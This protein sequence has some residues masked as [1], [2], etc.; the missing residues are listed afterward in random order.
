MVD[1]YALA[2]RL[3]GMLLMRN[4]QITI[5]EIQNLPFVRDKDEAYAVA[6]RLVQVFGHHH[7]IEFTSE[8]GGPDTRLSLNLTNVAERSKEDINLVPLK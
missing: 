3:A 6:Q 5:G 2:V 8:T 7:G 4:G 1:T